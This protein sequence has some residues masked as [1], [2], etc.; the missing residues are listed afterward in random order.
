MN[1]LDSG[2][3]IKKYLKCQL[4][5]QL[6]NLISLLATI[7]LGNYSS[8]ELEDESVKVITMVTVIEKNQLFQKLKR[9][10]I[11]FEFLLQSLKLSPFQATMRKP[12][13]PAKCRMENLQAEA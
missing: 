3:V 6:S 5:Q 1:S 8:N 7:G 2:T 11:V 13:T 9:K 12:S 4:Q 10:K